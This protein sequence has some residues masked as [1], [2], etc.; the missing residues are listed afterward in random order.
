MVVLQTRNSKY[1]TSNLIRKLKVNLKSLDDNVP[2]R[3]NY[4]KQSKFYEEVKVK[5]NLLKS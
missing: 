3:T 1:L 4:V 5:D 2:K